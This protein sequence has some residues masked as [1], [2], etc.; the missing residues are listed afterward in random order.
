MLRVRLSRRVHAFTLI[1]LLVVIA[2]IAILIGL[3]LPGVQKVREA[4]A[5]TKCQNN[6]KQLALALHSYHDVYGNLPS[7]RGGPQSAEY[8]LSPLV[9]IGPFLEQ[10]TVFNK[11]N[12]LPVTYGTVTYTSLPQP[13]AQDF[14]P[15]GI[16]FQ[17]P[18][19]HC[20]S[21]TP[22]YDK[23]NGRTGSI[24]STSYAFCWG[25]FVS[26]TGIQQSY[27]PRGMFG[28]RSSTK[29][30]DIVDG[31]GS[32]IMMS[33]RTFRLNT[34]R[35]TILGNAAKGVTG[36]NNNPT[37]C[38]LTVDRVAGIYIDPWGA[39]LNPYFAGVRF[40]DGSAEFTGF[41]TVL[42]PNSPTCYS[43]GV[44]A[45]GGAAGSNTDGIFSARSRHMAGVNASF[46]DG[47][48]RF[49]SERIDAGDSAS[50]E[51]KTGPSPY[52]TWGALGTINGG[53]IPAPF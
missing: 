24:A 38:L 19:L 14:D 51:R 4:A 10:T 13:W 23:R 35:T 6:L 27:T 42:P 16:A 8:R 21:D 50:P 26:G 52:G 46:A 34:N 32:S 5:R 2:I 47:S 36:I 11:I 22:R 3:L 39:N 45:P 12:D 20:P 41:N 25:D 48:V 40:N 30:T 43:G 44:A 53:D 18:N 28:F 7:G 49:I 29:L 1:E 15:W 37:L 9:F 31:T 33:E 17:M